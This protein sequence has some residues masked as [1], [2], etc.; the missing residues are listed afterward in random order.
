MVA[1]AARGQG[2]KGRGAGASRARP[3]GLAAPISGANEG[4]QLEGHQRQSMMLVACR[5]GKGGA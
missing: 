3:A 2:R 4:H 1:N 5:E